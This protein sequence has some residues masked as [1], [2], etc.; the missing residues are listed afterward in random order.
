M[1]LSHEF[2]QQDNQ[3]DLENVVQ[4]IVVEEVKKEPSRLKDLFADT[5]G[6]DDNEDKEMTSLRSKF[7][8]QKR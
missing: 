2:V 3:Q 4:K 7:N 1:N 8:P 5:T 6:A